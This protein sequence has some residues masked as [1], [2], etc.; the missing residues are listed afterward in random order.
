M[1]A[2]LDILN[3]VLDAVIGALAVALGAVAKT[4]LANIHS[5]EWTLGL[6]LAVSCWLIVSRR[7]STAVGVVLL[8]LAVFA[9]T[10]L[11]WKTGHTGASVQQ[12]ALAALGLHGLLKGRGW[13]LVKKGGAA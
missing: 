2:A 9:G 11:S 3:T 6:L 12:A 8:A 4:M 1:N 7:W 10:W 13:A 5:T